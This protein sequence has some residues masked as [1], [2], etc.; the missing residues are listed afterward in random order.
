LYLNSYDSARFNTYT[1]LDDVTKNSLGLVPNIQAPLKVILDF[2]ETDNRARLCMGRRQ[3]PL[4]VRISTTRTLLSLPGMA[5]MIRPRFHRCGGMLSSCTITMSPTEMFGDAWVQSLLSC[6]SWMYFS[7][8][9][10]QNWSLMAQTRRQR[11]K[12]SILVSV[13]GGLG[14]ARR[15]SPT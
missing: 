10:R 11:S 14:S 12:F 3:A 4:V 2:Q 6:S 7:D 8:Q 5:A 13:Y 15:A 9:R 1:Y